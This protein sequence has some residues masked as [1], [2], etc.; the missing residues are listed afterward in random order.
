MKPLC[1]A[2]HT[3]RIERRDWRHGLYQFL[4]YYRC[5]PHSTTGVSP[6][7]LLFNR[8]LSNG[9]PTVKHPNSGLLEQH[10]T[11][12][13]FD[14]QW[15]TKMKEYTDRRRHVKEPTIAV[16]D[17]VLMKKRNRDKFSTRYEPNPFQ[18]ISV[19]GTQVTAERSGLQR[20]RHISYFKP[21]HG[22]CDQ[23]LAER[24]SE[25]DEDEDI[26]DPQQPL[27]PP[28][29]AERRYPARQHESP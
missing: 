9:I 4:L 8:Q 24:S 29:A 18:V 12:A 25:S 16:G 19:K 10:R 27:Q 17:I 7:E 14:H 23:G 3:A 1:K 22:S 21:Y 11:A 28:A 13:S 26:S 15:K 20:T 2:V 5:T 6:A